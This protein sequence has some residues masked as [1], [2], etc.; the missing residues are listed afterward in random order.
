VDELEAQLM[1]G[2][3]A[4]HDEAGVE[5]DQHCGGA[6]ILMEKLE[7]PHQMMWMYDPTKLDLDAPVFDSW[8]DMREHMEEAE[9]PLKT[10][11]I[12]AK[13]DNWMDQCICV[14]RKVPPPP[15]PARRRVPPPPPRKR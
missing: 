10:E 7:Q 3:L 12:C 14:K 11:E 2:E 6:L 5:S 1:M 8:E 15:P 13:C 9:A 4:C